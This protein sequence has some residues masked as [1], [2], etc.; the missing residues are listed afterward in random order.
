MAPYTR[1]QLATL[2]LTVECSIAR[3]SERILAEMKNLN[4]RLF[5][6]SLFTTKIAAMAFTTRGSH[7]TRDLPR[8]SVKPYEAQEVAKNCS[9]Q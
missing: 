1:F 2:R 3:G 6:I 8:S 5:E 7:F 9:P 4:S